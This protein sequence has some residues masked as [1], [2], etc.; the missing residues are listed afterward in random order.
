MNDQLPPLIAGIGDRIAVYRQAARLS[1]TELGAAIGKSLPWVNQVENGHR[2]PDRLTD[3]INIARATRCTLPD[4]LGGPIDELTP[5][6]PPR[7]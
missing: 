2:T 7:R 5:G 1:Q 3:L 6:A 4:L